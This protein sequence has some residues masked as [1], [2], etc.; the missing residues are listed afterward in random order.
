MSKAP[1]RNHLSDAIYLVESIHLVDEA[2]PVAKTTVERSKAAAIKARLE[3]EKHQRWLED[4]QERYAE[5]VRGCQRRRKRQARLDIDDT[6][7]L[8]HRVTPGP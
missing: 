7:V 3:L 2:V 8:A 6:T 5:A 1:D 4:H